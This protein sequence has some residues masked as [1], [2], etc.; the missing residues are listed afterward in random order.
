MIRRF[1]SQLTMEVFWQANADHPMSSLHQRKDSGNHSNCQADGESS[2]NGNRGGL[3]V[4]HGD[5]PSNRTKRL[6]E[7]PPQI[8]LR[9]RL[10][11]GLRLGPTGRCFAIDHINPTSAVCLTPGKER[12]RPQPLMAR[13][14]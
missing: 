7:Q 4:H 14:S 5:T 12:K 13:A 6:R 2:D 9:L 10:S 8:I 1:V 3:N 11:H